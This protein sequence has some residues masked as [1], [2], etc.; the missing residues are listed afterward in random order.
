MWQT[1]SSDAI[2]LYWNMK[3]KEFNNIALIP[4][5]EAIKNYVFRTNYS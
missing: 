2:E 4:E 1:S 5:I 3:V